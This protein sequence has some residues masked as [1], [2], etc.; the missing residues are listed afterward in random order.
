MVVLVGIAAAV[1]LGVALASA[2]GELQEARAAR[3]DL[4]EVSSQ[5]AIEQSGAFAVQYVECAVPY[6]V[7]DRKVRTSEVGSA[8]S[9]WVAVDAGAAEV[10]SLDSSLRS[11]LMA[12]DDV[13]PGSNVTLNLCDAGCL[14]ELLGGQVESGEA[15]EIMQRYRLSVSF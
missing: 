14:P 7:L 9:Y 10:A 11:Q 12:E 6:V 1:L 13:E 15:L 2:C 3:V 5:R 4:E 8:A